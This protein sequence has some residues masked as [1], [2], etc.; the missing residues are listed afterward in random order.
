MMEFW[1]FGITDMLKTVYLLKLCF[2]GGIKRFLK[3]FTIYEH[4]GHLGHVTWTIWTNFLPSHR[5][6]IWIL[7][8]IG[9]VVFKQTT[10][11][12]LYYKFTNEPPIVRQPSFR[13]D[14]LRRGTVVKWAASWQNQ[15]ND[16]ASSKDSDQPGHLPSLISLRCVLNG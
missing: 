10:E 15:Q 16:C 8:L 12:Y 4:G 13:K 7:T 9:P 5:G 6:S 3:V 11:A 2:A 14:H 1:I